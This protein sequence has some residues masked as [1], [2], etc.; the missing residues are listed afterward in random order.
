MLTAACNATPNSLR[1]TDA[2]RQI[3]PTIP[4]KAVNDA[5]LPINQRFRTLDEYLAWLRQYAAPTDR[6]WY[7]EIKPGVYELQTDNFRPVEG[8]PGA[9]KRIFTREEL[10]RQFGFKS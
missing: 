4:G 6:A 1:Q 9:V 2:A 3:D 5:E 8:M 10:E 7:K